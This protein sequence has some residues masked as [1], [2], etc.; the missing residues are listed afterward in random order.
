G[1][2]NS[3]KDQAGEE[4]SAIREVKTRWIS[5]VV[6]PGE[7]LW[8]ISQKYGTKVEIIKMIN[9]LTNDDISEGMRLKILAKEDLISK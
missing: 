5:H 1:Q 4:K 9:K 8:Q 3:E 6:S 2:K 7:S